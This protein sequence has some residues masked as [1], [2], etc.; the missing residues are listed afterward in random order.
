M[1]VRELISLLW[2]YDPYARVDLI[3]NKN[4]TP[5]L[6]VVDDEILGVLLKEEETDSEYQQ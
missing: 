5:T 4:G 3:R 6:V 2:E 1:S